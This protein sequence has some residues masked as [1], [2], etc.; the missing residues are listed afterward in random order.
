MRKILRERKDDVDDMLW[1]L[2]LERK[3]LAEEAHFQLGEADEAL[4]DEGST[5]PFQ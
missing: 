4:V 2:D 5:K 3:R 1:R